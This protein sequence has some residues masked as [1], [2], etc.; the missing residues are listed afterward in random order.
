MRHSTTARRPRRAILAAVAAAAALVLSACSGG[1][2]AAPTTEL[3]DSG[4]EVD[5]ITVAFPGSL[6][7]LYIGQEAGILNYYLAATVQE[8]LVGIGADGQ[9]GPA[10]A[11]EWETPD[12]TTYVFTLRD[13]ATFQNGDLVTPED[14]VFSLEQAAN[15]ETSPNTAYYLMSLD[16]VKKTGDHEVT[17]TTTAPDASFLTAL[18]NVGA[19]TVTQQKFWEDNDGKV[20]TSQSLLMGTGPYEVTEFQPNSHVTLER[21]DTWWGELPKVKQIRVDFIPDENTRLLAAQKGDI[22]IAFNVPLNQAEQW[23]K[24]GDGRVEAVN[25]LSYVG[26]MFDQ[27]VAPFDDPDVRAAIASAVDRDAIV[28]KLLR[29][30]GEKATTIMTPESLSKAYSA[31]EARK[32]LA[33]IT[34]HD[35][36]L[37]QAK[38]LLEKSGSADGFTT[39]LTFPNTGPQ[40]GT[41]AQ[42]LA[43]NLKEIGI[44]VKVRE[45]PLE[46]WLATIGDGEHGLGFM[47]YFSTTG[48]PAEV[49][50]YMLGLENPNHFENQE[51]VDLVAQSGATTDPAERIDV[52]LELEQLNA[53]QTVNAPL[54]WGQSLTYFDNG[55]GVHDFTP[56]TF[57]GSWGSQ[58]FATK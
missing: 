51:A 1:G 45:V 14:V 52:L 9:F 30:Y 27:N 11:S 32:L 41:A 19:L 55:I 25:D 37:D 36:D 49:N 15:P 38:K 47:W 54:W 13:D 43:E 6:A 40:L 2:S 18:S 31:E 16:S 5:S 4:Q 23:K 20:G 42:S 53:D 44:T 22:D 58:L 29:G 8:G 3:V 12:D 26:L 28:D 10:I 21:V 57:L 34:Q 46:E 50:S 17:V 24:I 7:N 56:Y 35:F 39:E 48:D 33:G